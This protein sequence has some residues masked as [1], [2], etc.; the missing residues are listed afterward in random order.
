[1]L[2]V[3]L[4]NGAPE[5]HT[6]IVSMLPISVEAKTPGILLIFFCMSQRTSVSTVLDSFGVEQLTGAS[7]GSG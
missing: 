2:N 7:I 1:M 5:W 4:M 3:T 6:D